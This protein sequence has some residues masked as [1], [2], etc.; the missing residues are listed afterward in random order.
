MLYYSSS[1]L[2]YRFIYIFI[3]TKYSNKT[4]KISKQESRNVDIG[5]N[6]VFCLATLEAD[7]SD[8]TAAV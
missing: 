2:S 3:H 1:I 6:F 7:N 5:C 4:R 8:R